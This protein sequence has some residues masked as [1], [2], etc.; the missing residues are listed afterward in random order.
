MLWLAE[1]YVNISVYSVHRVN[2]NDTYVDVNAFSLL[3]KKPQGC[4]SH[5][6]K[7]DDLCDAKERSD[8]Q[9]AARRTL[10]E[11]GR[12]FAL[13]DA[14]ARQHQD[15]DVRKTFQHVLCCRS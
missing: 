13:Q 5:P 6:K 4:F 2:I 8:D 12:A 7:V 10:Q 11:G 1:T 9:S 15:D 14:S 3:S